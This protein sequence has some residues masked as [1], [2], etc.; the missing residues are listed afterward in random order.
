MGLRS[1][2]CFR[3]L[4]RLHHWAESS[5]LVY[6]EIR[7]TIHHS[8]VSDNHTWYFSHWCPS[9]RSS[10]LEKESRWRS[11]HLLLQVHLLIIRAFKNPN[12]FARLTNDL[13][14]I[15]IYKYQGKE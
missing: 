7:S 15:L 8:T 11:R 10:G 13:L 2:G 3:F 1:L 12:Q 6:G 5:K 4:P 14:M 9:L